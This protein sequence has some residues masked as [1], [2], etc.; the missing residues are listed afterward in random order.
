MPLGPMKGFPFVARDKVKQASDRS[1]FLNLQVCVCVISEGGNLDAVSLGVKKMI[2]TTLF[3]FS[4]GFNL[5]AKGHD[6][7]FV[8]CACRGLRKLCMREEPAEYQD[9]NRMVELVGFAPACFGYL[10]CPLYK[11]AL[12]PK[13]PRFPACLSFSVFR[14]SFLDVFGRRSPACPP[15]LTSFSDVLQLKYPR[16]PTQ[17]QRPA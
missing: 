11:A 1:M 2:V 9:G 13:Q 7:P 17:N 5:F 12:S 6:K 14:G 10:L 15:I 8:V 3:S 4:R 16:H